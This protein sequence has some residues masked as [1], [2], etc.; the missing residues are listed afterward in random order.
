M[1]T[2]ASTLTNAVDYTAWTIVKTAGE[3]HPPKQIKG[4][5]VRINGGFGLANKQFVTPTGA[6][7]TTVT[8]EELEFLTQHALFKKHVDGGFV[9]VH[10]S[11]RINGD[12]AIDG[13]STLD[14][15][16]PLSPASFKE[17]KLLD[18]TTPLT[19]STGPV[20]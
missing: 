6:V 20:R 4:R 14:K 10:K 7:L 1:P 2:V 5:S 15:S 13:M 19:V 3:Q 9:T 8:D 17:K 11:E 16:Q 12:R 18:A